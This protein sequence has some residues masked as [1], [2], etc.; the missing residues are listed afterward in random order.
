MYTQLEMKEQCSSA[1]VHIE[2]EIERNSDF[3]KVLLDAYLEDTL[4]D[5]IIPRVEK[6]L[7]DNGLIKG[8]KVT[9]KGKQFLDTG[10]V[11]V[12]ESG[13]YRVL[14]LCD[15]ITDDEDM[16]LSI[17]RIKPQKYEGSSSKSRSLKNWVYDC[18]QKQMVDINGKLSRCK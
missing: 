10:L 3:L 12:K 11:A 17:E 13:A 4:A 16:V 15:K 7:S 2:A 9:T 8:D 6:I 14:V 18:D 1:Q 5:E